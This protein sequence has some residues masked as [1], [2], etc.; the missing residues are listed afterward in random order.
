MVHCFIQRR[1][2]VKHIT[3]H[4][5]KKK[6]VPFLF[7]LLCQSTHRLNFFLCF[8]WYFFFLSSLLL[9]EHKAKWIM[10]FVAWLIFF[11]LLV[12][13]VCRAHKKRFSLFFVW[14][15]WWID[16]LHYFLYI[17]F[18][19][20]SHQWLSSRTFPW[21]RRRIGN[22]CDWFFTLFIRSFV[23]WSWSSVQH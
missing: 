5:K 22:W 12:V 17:F 3:E 9:F 4:T 19:K 21:L 6:F 8:I 18:V 1:I 2:I 7:K 23:R 10:N 16:L 11:F 13:V 14:F 15:L 20:G